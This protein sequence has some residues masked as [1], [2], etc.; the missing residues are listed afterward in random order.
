MLR[1]NAH[2]ERG[3]TLVEVLVAIV[4]AAIVGGL[5]VGFVARSAEQERSTT[6]HVLTLNEAKT[7]LERLTRDVRAADPIVA[8]ADD[9]L[10]VVVRNEGSSRCRRWSV[11]DDMTLT[12]QTQAEDTSDDSDRCDGVEDAGKQSQL[13]GLTTTSIFEYRP[14]DAVEEISTVRIDLEMATGEGNTVDLH[15][16]VTVRNAR[17]GE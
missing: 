5:T 15:D 10:T 7:A 9:A 6:S 4:I 12:V 2:D 14:E 16:E 13:H 3:F 1:R 11:V 8:A 17:V